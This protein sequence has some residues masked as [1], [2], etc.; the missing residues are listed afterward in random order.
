MSKKS[1]DRLGAE[2]E[3]L[4]RDIRAY[5]FLPSSLLDSHQWQVDFLLNKEFI[6]PRWHVYIGACLSVFFDPDMY[7]TEREI[8]LYS[9]VLF[10][11][12]SP[13][14]RAQAILLVIEPNQP[15]L[16]R[17]LNR[18]GAHWIPGGGRRTRARR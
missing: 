2:V 7:P 13:P 5:E 18:Q 15:K 9:S 17:F 3:Q 10:C 6:V 16:E 4:V 14:P 11:V 12:A 8:V 1:V